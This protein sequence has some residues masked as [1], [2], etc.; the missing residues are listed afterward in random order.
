MRRR[1]A[2]GRV[3]G[4][5]QRLISRTWRLVAV[6][7]ALVFAVALVALEGL[8]IGLIV[9]TSHRDAGRRVSQALA[10]PDALTAPPT[11]VWVYRLEG[12]KL[13][14]SAGAPQTPPD[15]DAVLSVSEGKRGRLHSVRY[16]DREYLVDTTDVK[17][18]TVQAALDLSDQERELHR[19]YL[20]LA[21]AGIAG[22]GTAALVGAQIA[23]RAIHPL[24]QALERQHQFV[25]DASHE[26]RTPLTQ[27]HTRAQLVARQYASGADPA[28]T[29]Q[30]IGALVR[31][32]RQLGELLEEM[33][34]AAQ[35][36]TEPQHFGPVD[37]AAIAREAVEAER[38]RAQERALSIGTAIG[39][40]PHLVRGIA[41]ALRRVLNALLDNAVG[42]T[43]EGGRI[44]VEVAVVADRAAVACTV[45]D[46]G[47]GFPQEEAQRLFERFARGHRGEGRRFGL[48][49]ALVQEA[50]QAHGGDVNATGSPGK[51]AAFTIT[52]PAWPADEPG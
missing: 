25:A 19:V 24:G 35:L 12:G 52:L 40:G 7:T 2:A 18:V 48:G 10:D 14:R 23:R 51:G 21:A 20:G 6:Q 38:P 15:L 8:A 37:L 22:L 42:H 33:L 5:E 28:R 27:L 3:R 11:G 41:P 26:L 9:Y 4:P 46:N 29:G 44:E 47:V 16:R 50:V 43:G 1:R 13:D 30:D 31:G 36:R 32:T 17:G 45:R 39:P 49:L 34:L